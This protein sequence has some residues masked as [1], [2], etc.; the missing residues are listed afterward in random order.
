MH[1]SP[2]SPT[3]PG[4]TPLDHILPEAIALDAGAETFGERLARL[5]KAA[6]MTQAGLAGRLGVSMTAICYWE[7]DRSRPKPERIEALAA[8]LDATPGALLE[9]ARAPASQNFQH[10]VARARIEIANAAGIAPAKVKIVI[11]I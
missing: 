2:L 3:T 4:A 6:G 7:Q 9:P 1:N 8:A 5:R 11:E 10:L